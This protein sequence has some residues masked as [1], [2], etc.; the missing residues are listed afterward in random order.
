MGN[1]S[2]LIQTLC[3]N[4]RLNLRF[5][6]LPVLASF[7]LHWSICRP[8]HFQNLGPNGSGKVIQRLIEGLSW[9]FG[10]ALVLIGCN[11]IFEPGLFGDSL[12][13]SMILSDPISI[14]NIT[15]KMS[16]LDLAPSK[17]PSP[18]LNTTLC[19]QEAT[20]TTAAP[21]RLVP[22]APMISK[23]PWGFT[24]APLIPRPPAPPPPPETPVETV[25][26][27]ETPAAPPI[28]ATVPRL[29]GRAGFTSSP[30]CIV[31]P[32]PRVLVQPHTSPL[33]PESEPDSPLSP[34]SPGSPL[35][36]GSLASLNHYRAN[37]QLWKHRASLAV[38]PVPEAL[39]EAQRRSRVLSDERWAF[40]LK[41][42][43]S[44][45]HD[46]YHHDLLISQIICMMYKSIC[47]I[48]SKH[49][50]NI[51][52]LPSQTVKSPLESCLDWWYNETALRPARAMVVYDWSGPMSNMDF[53]WKCLDCI[54]WCRMCF[55]FFCW[56]NDPNTKCPKP[57][58]FMLV[59][60]WNLQ[61]VGCFFSD[62]S[63]TTSPFLL[64]YVG[65]V[66]TTYK[67]CWFVHCFFL[68]PNRLR[69][70]S[71]TSEMAEDRQRRAEHL[72]RQRDKLLGKRRKVW[73]EMVGRRI[74]GKHGF[75]DL[76]INWDEGRWQG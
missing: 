75:Y 4:R 35:S 61:T 73:L 46:G 52:G 33:P 74:W 59:C 76:P 17:S 29:P 27:V 54:Y 48:L 9:F 15:N 49:Q 11:P 22:V 2:G 45:H 62:T 3:R 34:K 71:G 67:P 25:E 36:P 13:A 58:W 37:L 26:T 69:A 51:K 21:P 55:G 6:C 19:P 1:L 40:H 30:L 10:T 65:F 23:K 66:I 57:C 70:D 39:K 8:S 64:V 12:K 72:R 42:D 38:E 63:I 56:V 68:S 41:H 44:W 5:H 24:S 60:N 32:K 31:P 14:L 20:A 16:R 50:R 47:V 28:P 7:Q 43:G 18:E 53:L